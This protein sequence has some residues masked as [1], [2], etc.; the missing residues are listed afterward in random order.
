MSINIINRAVSGRFGT[1]LPFYNRLEYIFSARNKGFNSSNGLWRV[2]N[3]K[4]PTFQFSSKYATLQSIEY[5]ETRGGNDFTGVTFSVG[6][7]AGIKQRAYKEDG[8]QLNAYFSDYSYILPT[9]APNSRWVLKIVTFDGLTETFYSEEF[10]TSN[11]CG[12]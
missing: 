9:P 1:G 3:N 5:L 11:C 10:I 12:S 2:P 6:L 4:I 8:T 7:A